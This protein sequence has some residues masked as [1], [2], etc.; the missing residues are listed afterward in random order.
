MKNL[1]QLWYI[2]YV[3]GKPHDLISSYVADRY[4]YVNALNSVHPRINVA[5]GAPQGSC[6]GSLL[7]LLY[8]NNIISASN[9][10]TTLFPDDTC[11]MIANKNLKQLETSVTAELERINSWFRQNKL[12]LNETKTHYLS[13]NKKPHKSCNNDFKIFLNKVVINRAST[14]KYFGVPID[15]KL[16]WD[17]HVQNLS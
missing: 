6:L 2:Q 3:R 10:D 17:S 16:N 14:V 11:L 5:C 13:I 4:Q 8:V 12:T 15:E 1:Q 7:F 9:F